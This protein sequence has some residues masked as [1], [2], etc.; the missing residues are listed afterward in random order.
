MKKRWIGIV[1][2][3]FLVAASFAGCGAA[4]VASAAQ[5][6]GEEQDGN[7]ALSIAEQ[8]MQ[9]IFGFAGQS[10]Q[11]GTEGQT[12]PGGQGMDETEGA[13]ETEDTAKVLGLTEDGSGNGYFR[14]S[15]QLEETPEEAVYS[16][17]TGNEDEYTRIYAITAR[18]AVY[19]V[20]LSYLTLDMSG[21]NFEL[22]EDETIF[23][24]DTMKA[25]DYLLLSTMI[26]ESFPTI[27]VF[28]EDEKGNAYG[29]SI[30]ES[31][32]DG[33]LFLGAIGAETGS[34]A[35]IDE[36]GLKAM[37]DACTG[38][39][40]T[41]GSSLRQAQAAAELLAWAEANPT[42][43]VSTGIV[44]RQ[45][46]ADYPEETKA[47]FWENWPQVVLL[48]NDAIDD[49]ESVKGT[50]EDAGCLEKAQTA[51]ESYML[52]DHWDTLLETMEECR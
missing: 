16:N 6:A 17:V 2:S 33:S 9:K 8:I 46:L 34:E 25:G 49:L 19:H 13:Q 48:A 23:E 39:G 37:M 26:P 14:I 41:A 52:S 20:R 50:F 38:W 43:S 35:P 11:E 22:S 30:S 4:N 42:W 47:N 1:L 12:A 32:M 40:A 44:I 7:A 36:E 3:V 28:W 10:D 29:R 21:E 31:G 27:G 5:D 18:A 24:A 15:D 45:V 51:V